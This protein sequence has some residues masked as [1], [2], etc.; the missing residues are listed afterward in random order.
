[1]LLW[2]VLTFI[3]ALGVCLAKDGKARNTFG[4]LLVSWLL[5]SGGL[6]LLGGPAID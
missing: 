4:V 2:S 1:M 5:L 6:Y 3:L